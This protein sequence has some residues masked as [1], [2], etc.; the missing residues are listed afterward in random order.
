MPLLPFGSPP[1]Q[2]PIPV[3]KGGTGNANGQLVPT[4]NVT[5]NLGSTANYY[6]YIY[7]SRYYLNSTAYLDGATAG[8]VG[9]TGKLAVNAASDPLSWAIF[10]SNGGFR[11]DDD[12]RFQKSSGPQ[13]IARLNSSGSGAQTGYD[14]V[15]QV[16]NDNIT[17]FGSGGFVINNQSDS[18]NYFQVNGGTHSTSFYVD[19]SGNVQ[20]GNAAVATTATNGFLYIP[21]SAGTPTGTP[22][23]K[24][25]LVPMVYDT[26]NHKFWI[27]D[28]SA[29]AWKGVVL[30]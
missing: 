17:L 13:Y 20:V 16:H 25:G 19:T 21:T 3:T 6:Q 9:I 28:T 2:Y 29:S 15:F 18:A 30:T 24:T 27:Y 26:T 1:T 5:Y 12:F 11:A 8:W 23:S 14:L 10:Y 4:A 22:T 7:G